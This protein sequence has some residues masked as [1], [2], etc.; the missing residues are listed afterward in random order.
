MIPL[1]NSILLVTTIAVNSCYYKHLNQIQMYIEIANEILKKNR[2]QTRPASLKRGLKK[3][4]LSNEKLTVAM[5][6]AAVDR[7][8]E[9]YF[10]PP[11]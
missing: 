4:N 11:V 6:T 1:N 3:K 9:R 2:S 5:P 7:D 8:A 10:I